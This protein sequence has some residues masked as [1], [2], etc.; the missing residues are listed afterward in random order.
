M[1]VMAMPV[2][3]FRAVEHL[4][5]LVLDAFLH[6]G[7]GESFGAAEREGYP[8]LLS[9]YLQFL[10]L[11]IVAD[12]DFHRLSFPSERKDRATQL[13]E[14]TLSEKRAQQSKA[15]HVPLRRTP[16]VGVGEAVCVSLA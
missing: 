5:K 6:F 1:A 2:V 13:H 8:H 15:T 3:V 12:F 10:K 16:V 4:I 7:V 9:V 11:V 14:G